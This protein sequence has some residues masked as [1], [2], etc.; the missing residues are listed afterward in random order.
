MAR[1]NCECDEKIPSLIN[2][3]SSLVAKDNNK[4]SRNSDKVSSITSLT[5]YGLNSAMSRP[6]IQKLVT[7][8][9]F[10]TQNAWMPTTSI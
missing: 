4:T 7:I 10:T 3:Y 2:R 6:F 1:D 5:Y 8:C 9:A